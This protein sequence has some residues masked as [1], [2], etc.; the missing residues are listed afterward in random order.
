MNFAAILALLLQSGVC[1]QTRF[2]SPD[3]A[4]LTVVVCPMQQLPTVTAV[5]EADP[6]LPI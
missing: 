1:A 4:G 5:P 6:G 2:Q 3:G